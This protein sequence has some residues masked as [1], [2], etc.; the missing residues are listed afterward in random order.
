MTNEI[1]IRI[2][3]LVLIVL[4]YFAGVW[5][6]EKRH[7]AKDSGERIRFVFDTY[8]GFRRISRTAGFDGLQK[9][10]ISTLKSN[11]EIQ[12]LLD[13]IVNHGENHPLG[14]NHENIF[15][16][17]DLL[18]FFQYSTKEK[19]NFFSV[20]IDQIIRDSDSRS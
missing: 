11:E 8:M 3:G 15:Q 19:I 2:G 10:G 16:G 14:P 9:S 4:A 20:S 13:L 1:L 7:A 5:R 17:V 12:E 6:T 18:K